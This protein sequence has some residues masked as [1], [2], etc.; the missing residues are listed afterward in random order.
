MIDRRIIKDGKR[1]DFTFENKGYKTNINNG[2]P[3]GNGNA[4]GSVIESAL[5]KDVDCSL[6]IEHVV[7]VKDT[8][9][10][11]YWFMWYD[12]SGLSNMAMSSVFGKEELIAIINNIKDIGF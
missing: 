9:D 2:Y 1:L 7:S 3:H 8:S 5:Y 6:W 12:N 4:K 10:Q 11:C